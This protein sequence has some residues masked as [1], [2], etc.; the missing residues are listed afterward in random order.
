MDLE[1][2]KKIRLF[3]ENRNFLFNHIKSNCVCLSGSK[4]IDLF[5]EK[6]EKYLRACY[7]VDE[8]QE[9]EIL[10]MI[11][12][13]KKLY[14]ECFSKEAKTPL[15]FPKIHENIKHITLTTNEAFKTITYNIS[16][17]NIKDIDSNFLNDK[18]LVYFWVG[19][20]SYINKS[21]LDVLAKN[22]IRHKIRK[23]HDTCYC[24][25]YIFDIMRYLKVDSIKKRFSTGF[26]PLIFL[27]KDNEISQKHS[28]SFMLFTKNKPKVFHA[29]PRKKRTDTIKNKS[30]I[31]FN[32]FTYNHI[33]YKDKMFFDFDELP[34]TYK[35]KNIIYKISSVLYC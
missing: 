15:F 1:K 19:D 11:D 12:D 23:I 18:N 22:H 4:S 26:Q 21:F 35:E 7:Y 2:R 34:P 8:T 25:M 6:E 31:Y 10:K 13:L 28:Y 27:S 17:E 3:Y 5:I 16:D 24:I 14:F 20:S 30:K 33:W 9:Q 29:N 32:C